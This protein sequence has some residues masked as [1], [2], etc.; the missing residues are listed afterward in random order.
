LSILIYLTFDVDMKV[1][2]SYGKQSNDRLLQFY[3]FVDADNVFDSYDFNCGVLELILKYA[4]DITNIDPIPTSPNLTP[5]QRLQVI[6]E[7]LENTPLVNEDSSSLS[8]RAVS[9]HTVRVFRST[10]ASS[11]KKQETSK[12]VNGEDSSAVL[13]NVADILSKKKESTALT[14]RFDD[15]TVRALRALFSSSTEWKSLFPATSG[16][17]LL[18]NV[19]FYFISSNYG[20]ISSE[21][22]TAGQAFECG[23]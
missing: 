9:A 19:S 6:A 15:L 14:S 4:D 8:K 2:I 22:G 10:P 16:S 5:Q 11:V 23:H 3:G 13:Q 17:L 18:F 12:S 21:S 20:T 1:F 7:A